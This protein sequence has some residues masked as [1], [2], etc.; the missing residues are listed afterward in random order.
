MN[1]ECPTAAEIDAAF[2]VIADFLAAA[3]Y[4]EEQA[5][6]AVPS[7]DAACREA[8]VT[9]KSRY[10]LAVVRGRFSNVYAPGK[11]TVP[12]YDAAFGI[13]GGTPLGGEAVNVAALVGTPGHG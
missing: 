2:K 9:L 11:A 3:R 5:N 12:L 7:V 13:Q 8:F 10:G 4:D 6:M 1:D